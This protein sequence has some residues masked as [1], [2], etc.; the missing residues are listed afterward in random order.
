MPVRK[1]RQDQKNRR[2]RTRYRHQ[3]LLKHDLEY[4]KAGG[5]IA[6]IDEAG[7][8]PLAG[9]VVAAC[10]VLDYAKQDKLVGLDDS[11]QLS[12]AKRTF[13]AEEVK[14]NATAWSV[15]QASVAEIDRINIRRASI[16]AMRRALEAVLEQ[17]PQIAQL[18]VDAHT[19]D[20][21][22][23]AQAS[24]VR[25]DAT[26]LSIAAASVLAK[27]ERDAYMVKIAK[28]FPSYGFEKHKGY[29]TAAHLEAL[30][31]HGVTRIHR[32]TFEPVY[33][34]LHQPSLFEHRPSRS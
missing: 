5:I 26:S 6:G 17:E 24:I 11:K 4:T 18:L 15:A 8:G 31:A 29:G 14:K 16:L 19:I 27:T 2:R 13:L 23:I 9:P 28:K 32:R 12:D 21:T 3:Q 10:V 7:A 22:T 34:L 25:G 33:T 1:L 20:G 30:S